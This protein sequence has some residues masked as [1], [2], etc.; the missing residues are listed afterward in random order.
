MTEKIFVNGLFPKEGRQ[1]WIK[2]SI[3]VKVEELAKFLIDQKDRANRNNGWLSIEIKEG[4]KGW[5]AELNTFE[6]DKISASDQAPDREQT[7]F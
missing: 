7:P 1:E 4:R 2:C 6:K 5:Y 3:N